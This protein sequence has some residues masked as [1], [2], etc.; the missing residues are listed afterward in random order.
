MEITGE[1]SLPA[2]QIRK[3][4][5]RGILTVARFA[6]IGAGNGGR[7]M[8]GHLR[9][10]GHD[11]VLFNRDDPTENE[12]LL[13]PLVTS[14]AIEVVGAIEGV[15]RG[16]EITTS[17]KQ[18][19]QGA[20]V[21]FVVVPAVAHAALAKEMAPLLVAGQ[22]VVLTPGRTFGAYEFLHVLRENGCSHRLTVGETYS[23]PYTA[24][25]QPGNRVIVTRVKDW[26]PVATIPARDVD[27]LV[28][29]LSPLFPGLLATEH[30]LYTS[31]LNIGAM[32]HPAGTLLNA[33]R[34][35]QSGGGFPFYTEGMTPSVCRVIERLDEERRAIARRF[36][37][38]LPS[39]LEMTARAYGVR[40]DSLYEVLRANAAYDVGQAPNSLSHRYVYEDTSTGLVPMVSLAELIC[41]PVPV[42]RAMVEL[43]SAMTGTDFWETG[44]NLRRLGLAYDDASVLVEALRRGDVQ[45]VAV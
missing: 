21:I 17:L 25:L 43:A 5:K 27:E 30:V 8:A 40:G 35:E 41:V 45:S 26:L 6:V 23:L 14:G 33:A 29:K 24:R 13:K 10:A 12:R 28:D 7:A 22:T 16:V 39:A 36:G 4:R 42:M 15:A 9:L 31:L 2:G 1:R 32:F 34:I 11:V 37:L 18:A 3:N 44:R 20:E 38:D 19:V